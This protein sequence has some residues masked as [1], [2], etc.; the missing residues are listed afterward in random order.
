MTACSRSKERPCTKRR[1]PG[2]DERRA[3]RCASV[4]PPPTLS[5]FGRGGRTWPLTPRAVSDRDAMEE[6]SQIACPS[7]GLGFPDDAS[8]RR[9][10]ASHV[11]RW[12]CT[13]A[14]GT[15]AVVLLVGRWL[16]LAPLSRPHAMLKHV[17]LAQVSC[18][19][20]RRAREPRCA[21]GR[22]GGAGASAR[23]ARSTGGR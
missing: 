20:A 16:A 6:R 22:R 2:G 19:R 9:A 11:S 15:Q 5:N 13:C 23:Q 4:A 3:R 18:Q 12:A 1:R 10:C 14:R 8:G 7:C 21:A 17:L